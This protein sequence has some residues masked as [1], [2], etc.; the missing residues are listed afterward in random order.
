MGI[1]DEEKSTKSFSNASS[2]AT[3]EAM[4]LKRH[5]HITRTVA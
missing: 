5:D 3:A 2:L 4:I 1:V